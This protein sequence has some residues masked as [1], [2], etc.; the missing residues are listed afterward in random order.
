MRLPAAARRVVVRN[1][2]I[3]VV[4][5][6]V[7]VLCVINQRP[8]HDWGDDFALYLRQSK[9]LVEGN[10]GEV[11]ASNRFT[12]EESPW[13]GFSALSV[14]WGAPVLFAPVVALF[15][16]DYAKLKLLETLFLAGFLF[17]FYKIVARRVGSAGGLVLAALIG[18]SVDYAGWTNTVLAEF[19]YM[20]FL[21]LTLWWIDRCEARGS[22]EEGP[23]RPLIVL[24][25]LIGFTYNIRREGVVLVLALAAVLA[26]H[27]W[28]RRRRQVPGPVP[29]RRLA[30][31]FLSAGAFVVG[32]QLVLPTVLLPQY[33]EAG[34][35]NLKDNILW[36]HKIIY[37]LIG[38]KDSGATP[39]D[40]LGSNDLAFVLLVMFLVFAGIGV[41][42]RTIN[43]FHRDASFLAVLFGSVLVIGRLPFHDGRYIYSVVPFVAYFAYQ[44]VASTLEAILVTPEAPR[45]TKRIPTIVAVAF[46]AVFALGNATDMYRRTVRSVVSGPHTAVWGPEHP[47]SLE[48]FA[49][50]RRLTRRDDVLSFFR[51]RAMNLY[52]ERQTLQLTRVDHILK[53]VDWYVMR[54]D[55]NY[56]QVLI[57]DEEA[58]EVGLELVWQN[59]KYII[60]R[61][62]PRQ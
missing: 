17:F 45:R 47:Q 61:V 8:G 58:A 40:Y 24:G 44:G 14:P 50:V 21:A 25:L 48:M 3:L 2:P 34:F 22:W 26:A 19:P 56:S 53:R 23:R 4:I 54:K 10:V 15:G 9:A 28:R 20:L 49:A 60:W 13:K 33:S 39:A 1:W 52:A 31:P 37:E 29:W 18:L 38:L 36:Y 27:L 59:P 43:H 6:L 35:H 5:T 42:I 30:T 11:L 46:I 41:L 57:S 12:V 32:L 7:S 16:L 55:S 62:P 51:A